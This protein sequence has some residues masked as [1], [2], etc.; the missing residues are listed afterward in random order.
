[1]QKNNLLVLVLVCTVTTSIVE[2]MA[3]EVSSSYEVLSELVNATLK[4]NP[5]VQSAQAA[6]DAA[7]ARER[8]GNQPLYN[9]QIQLDAEDA[10]DRSASIGISQS[11]DWS[12]KRRAR[13][14]VAS[15]EREVVAA[16]LHRIRQGLAIELLNALIRHDVAKQLS[17]LIGERERLMRQFAALAAQRRQAG[18]LNQ[19]E[20]DLAR[21][22][23]AEAQL[24]QSQAT[25]TL[26]EV[27]QAVAAVLGDKG[28]PLAILPDTPPRAAVETPDIEQLLA[29]LPVVRVQMAR[30]AAASKRVKLRT[31]ETRPDPTVGVRIGQEESDL[32]AG[33]NISI[34][35]FVRNNFSAQVDGANA[36]RL[37]IELEAQDLYRRARAQM[38]TSLERYQLTD[39][40]WD[41]WKKIGA[42]SLGSQI[43]V[44]ERLWRAGEISTT[45]YLVQV[46]QTLDTRTAAAELRGRLW[47]SWFDWLAASGKVDA[48]LGLTPMVKAVR[49]D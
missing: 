19:V 34:P 11:I 45:D 7:I 2:V 40:A 35:L 43:T 41:N 21:L 25:F 31:L 46:N 39:R 29:N 18:D 26:A 9:P 30:I 49:N 8:A 42:Q 32:L 16:E 27:R 38:T 5:G 23:L 1:M 36:D 22:A 3:D 33:L 24:Q 14:S 20:L 17:M 12:G 37:Q 6:L 44:L 28:S 13:G 4:S 10:I 48:W 47:Q 15:Y